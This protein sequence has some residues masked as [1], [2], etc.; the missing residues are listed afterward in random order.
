MACKPKL[1][2]K[3]MHGRILPRRAFNPYG[4]TMKMNSRYHR[5]LN[6]YEK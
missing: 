2:N 6:Y 4:Y 5:L 3:Q 1:Q